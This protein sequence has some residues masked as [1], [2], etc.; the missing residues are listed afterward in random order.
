VPYPSC[1]QYHAFVIRSP[2]LRIQKS[3][4]PYGVGASTNRGLSSDSPGC[5]DFLQLLIFNCFPSPVGFLY[6]L[7]VLHRSTLCHLLLYPFVRLL[8]FGLLAGAFLWV[9]E[10]PGSSLTL[11]FVK[12]HFKDSGLLNCRSWQMGL[13]PGGLKS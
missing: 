13:R 1:C 12:G 5:L 10:L 9:Q 3:K 4:V 11:F 2:L 8:S 6:Y 7:Y